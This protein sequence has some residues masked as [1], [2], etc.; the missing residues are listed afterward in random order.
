MNC[1]DKGRIREWLLGENSSLLSD[2]EWEHLS[3]CTSCQDTIKVVW[4]T[5]RS[6]SLPIYN[7]LHKA[8]EQCVQKF[9][10][11]V[12]L[13]YL[14]DRMDTPERSAF[15]SHLPG[16]ASCRNSILHLESE[17]SEF[18]QADIE[19]P[20]FIL[21]KARAIGEAEIARNPGQAPIGLM[22]RVFGWMSGS[23]LRPQWVGAAAAVV[24]LLLAGIAIY[25]R[26][27]RSVPPNEIAGNKTGT[28]APV[29]PTTPQ[30]DPAAVKNAQEILAEI[31]RVADGTRGRPIQLNVV[32]SDQYIAE[33]SPKGE[34]T[35]STRYLA[36]AQDRDEL[37]FL[38]AHEVAHLE[39]PAQC[40][41]SFSSNSQA[42]PLLPRQ[43]Q[44]IELQADRL[45]VFL[46]SVAGFRA[47]AARD[48]FQ[49][50]QQ[51][52]KASDASHPEV[53]ARL[54][55]AASELNSIEQ[56]IDLFRAGIS[57]FN[58]EQYSRSVAVFEQVSKLFPSREAYNNLGLAYH[59]FALEYSPENWGFKKSV[60]L[61]PVAR[62]IEPIREELPKDNLFLLYLDKAIA[63]YQ[64]AMARDPQY[65]AVGINLAGALDDKGDE[66]GARKQLQRVLNLKPTP[67]ERARALN[68]LGVIAA[69]QSQLDKASEF[70]RQAAQ[71]DAHFADPH[72]NQARVQELKNNVTAA[73]MEYQRYADLSSGDRDGW[74]RMAYNKLNRPW[75]RREDDSQEKLPQLADLQL[76]S[77]ISTLTRKLGPATAIWK[78]RTPLDFDFSVLLFDKPGLIVSGSEDTI[79]FIQTTGTY[80]QTDSANRLS[81]GLEAKTLASRTQSSVRIVLPGSRE[82]LVDFDRGLGITLRQ[83]R[84]ESWFVFEPLD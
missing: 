73:R 29:S 7:E 66:E 55:E 21:S 81:P 41:L 79:D 63:E 74:L 42:T 35:I 23:G 20:A 37:A 10:D 40:I 43:Q 51:V 52:P 64:Q 46:A 30:V 2:A 17:I 72:F 32:P 5:T 60:I 9:D 48:L 15:E 58:T 38:L 49:Q 84:V 14:D 65:V 16:C 22:D 31:L 71:I 54:G 4:A 33:I 1:L 57:F 26:I 45:G 75:P 12:R 83:S 67:A 70:F 25:H 47:D 19:V 76:G 28:P 13:A 27:P 62:A 56:S 8:S 77:R 11:E 53:Q 3:S 50:I 82:S 59:K 68:N 34:L 61:D 36:L 18:E 39:H 80:R 78:L 6:A 44:Q 24:I 69:K